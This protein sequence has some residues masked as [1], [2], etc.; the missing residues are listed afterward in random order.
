V[1]AVAI[2]GSYGGDALHE[3]SN[4]ATALQVQAGS[5]TP[6]NAFRVKAKLNRKTGGATVTATVPG[7][8]RLV[9]KG[10]GV[11]RV[12]RS[13][14]HAGRVALAVKPSAMTKRKLARRGKAKVAIAVAFTPDG[15]LSRTSRLSLMLKLAP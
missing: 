15:G 6:S 1:G 2:S 8:G 9:L 14:A 13:A 5:P 7:P 3:P 12:S 10:S 4:G 11:K